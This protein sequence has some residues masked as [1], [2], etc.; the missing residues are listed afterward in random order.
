MGDDYAQPGTFDEA[1]AAAFGDRASDFSDDLKARLRQ[2]YG[3]GRTD[4]RRASRVLVQEA[5]F[6]MEHA[7]HAAR[8]D[9]KWERERSLDVMRRAMEETEGYR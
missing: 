6:H 3:H 8:A 9:D 4:G 1:L 5:R 7:M 2:L